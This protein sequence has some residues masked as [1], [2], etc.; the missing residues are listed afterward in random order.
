MRDVIILLTRRNNYIK[1][2][3]KLIVFDSQLQVDAVVLL[4]ETGLGSHRDAGK[5]F[6]L[7]V[8]AGLCL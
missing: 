4:E 3:K 1:I 6:S 5:N 2:T 7:L 8:V